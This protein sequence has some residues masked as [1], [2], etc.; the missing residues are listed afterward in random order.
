MVLAVL[1]LSI[2]WC[3]PHLGVSCTDLNSSSIGVVT[4]N[5]SSGSFNHNSCSSSSFVLL[6]HLCS[7]RPSDPHNGFPPT[8]FHASTVGRWGTLLVNDV[9]PRKA[10]HHE[11]RHLWSISRGA[12]RGALQH[13]LA[14]LTT[15]PW[16]RSPQEKKC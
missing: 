5:T 11:L 9:S 4:C 8:T 15:P 2:V 14:A 1:L 6:L 3:I 12:Y 16:I 13:E 10:T 7:R